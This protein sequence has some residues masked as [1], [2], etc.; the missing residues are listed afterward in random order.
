MLAF[1]AISA[2]AVLT[3]VRFVAEGISPIAID[4]RDPEERS[5]IVR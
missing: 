3:I 1:A 2:V 5:S 4:A